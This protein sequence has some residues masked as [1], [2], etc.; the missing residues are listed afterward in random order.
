MGHLILGPRDKETPVKFFL[1]ARPTRPHPITVTDSLSSKRKLGNT[2]L[3]FF[4]P[5]N[6]ST[7]V[8]LLLA[9]TLSHMW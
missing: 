8:E 9:Y 2:E 4:S 7:V 3:L 1:P 6:C 5:L